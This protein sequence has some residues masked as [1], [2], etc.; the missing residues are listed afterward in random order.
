MQTLAEKEVGTT[1]RE[2]GF[3]PWCLVSERLVIRAGRRRLPLLRNGFAKPGFQNPEDFLGVQSC[4]LFEY[5]HLECTN[6]EI[7]E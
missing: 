4:R 7:E 6:D 5:Q 3:F 2:L 1:S